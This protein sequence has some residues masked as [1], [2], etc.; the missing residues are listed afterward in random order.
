MN[1]LVAAALESA[2]A[3]SHRLPAHRPPNVKSFEVEAD[4]DLGTIWVTRKADSNASI[5][6]QQLLDSQVVDE[7]IGRYL[8]RGNRFKVV[9]SAQRD[10]FSLGG[11]LSFF[12]DCIACRD[13]NGLASYA[14]LAV[15]AVANNLSGHG[16]C[17]LYTVALV[18]GETQGGGFEA[19]LSCH[20]IVA[21]R[22]SYF[23]FPEPLFGMFPGMGGQS[24][25]AARVGESVATRITR[26]ANR[27]PAE[28]LYEIGVIDYLAELGSGAAFVSR[29]VLRAQIETSP[30]ARR[31][32]ERREQLRSVTRHDLDE[33]VANWTAQAMTL[34]GRQIRTM[35]YIIEMQ[36]RRVA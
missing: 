30:E 9:G 14:A 32:A 1:A 27:Y 35:K 26:S 21:E 6:Q 16:A 29:L 4:A 25:L 13:Q 18:T 20:L 10:I 3:R 7:A 24:L 12:V 11:D 8:H 34:N 33:S 15:D 5:T 22:G 31:L 28:F 19:A 36:S 17:N 23:G 2:S